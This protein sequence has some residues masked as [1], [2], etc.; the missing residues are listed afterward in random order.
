MFSESLKTF[1]RA[2][3]LCEIEGGTF[4]LVE[5][6]NHYAAAKERDKAL[7]II[8]GISKDAKLRYISEY[9]IATVYASLGEVDQAFEWLERSYGSRDPWLEHLRVDPRWA[10]IRG[11]E[12]FN[13]LVQRIEGL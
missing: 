5:L 1:E 6:A 10:N 9:S 13:E 8:A 3:E 12:K 4:E 7:E 11:Y 2:R